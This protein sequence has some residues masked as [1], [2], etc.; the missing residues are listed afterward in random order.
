MLLLISL[1]CSVVLLFRI[2]I[3]I[4]SRISFGMIRCNVLFDLVLLMIVMLVL[5][6]HLCMLE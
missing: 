2:S 4:T 1:A 5:P 3:N 6:V